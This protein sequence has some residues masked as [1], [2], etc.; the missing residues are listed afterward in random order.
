MKIKGAVLREPGMGNGYSIEEL[1]LEPP[2][3]KEALVRYAYAGYC[4]S[5][6]SNL[7][8][9]IDRISE[10]KIDIPDFS[11]PD[12]PRAGGQILSK[13][14]VSIAVSTIKKGAA[15]ES[16]S[17]ALE[18]GYKGFGEI[19]CSAAAKEGI[20]AFLERRKPDFKK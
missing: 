18:I 17:E 8:G 4:H 2:R 10:G 1:E 20:S 3:K 15:T 7:Q 14:A 6:L 16:L 11:V 9:K 13:E 12:E 5:D 19:A